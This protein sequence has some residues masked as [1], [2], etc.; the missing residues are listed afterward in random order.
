MTNAQYIPKNSL[1]S[2]RF[3]GLAEGQAVRIWANDLM[4]ETVFWN[5][6][7][8][9]QQAVG[10]PCEITLQVTVGKNDVELLVFDNGVGF[11]RDFAGIAFVEQFSSKGVDRGRGLLEVLDAVRRLRGTVE[12]VETRTGSYRIRMRFPLLS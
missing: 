2:L 4:L 8:N 3:E 1:L 12:V 5:I 6:W 11:P 9:A 10:S 7:K